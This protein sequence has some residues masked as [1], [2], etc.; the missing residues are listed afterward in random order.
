MIYK[1]IGFLLLMLLYTNSYS[2]NTGFE[3]VLEI[4][5]NELLGTFITDMTMGSDGTIAVALNDLSRVHLYDLKGELISEYG[6]SGR[7][8]GDFSN[9]MSVHVSDSIIYAMDAGP[10]GKVNAF[11]KNDPG[12]FQ[13]FGIPR[14]RNSF[15]LRMWAL[16]GGKFVVE[17]R[18]SYSNMNLEKTIMST[19]SVISVKDERLLN[20]VFQHESAEKFINSS[21]GGFSISDMPYGRENFVMPIEG[22]IYHNWSGKKNVTRLNINNADT[23]DVIEPQFSA[24]RLSLNDQ[25]YRRYFLRELGIS[26]GDNFNEVI[27]EL[28]NDPSTRARIRGLQAKL[29]NRDELHHTFPV[30]EWVVGDS[31]SLCFGVPDAD[32]SLTRVECTDLNG[33]VSRSG[34]IGSSVNILGLQDQ[35]LYGTRALETG[36]TSVVV[37]EMR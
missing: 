20:E 18:P 3:P 29:E 2:Q 11:D 30:Y 10:G 31:G 9:L 17:Y 13:A 36:L 26:D 14:M 22:E 23:I 32:R 8:P 33:E 5:P 28:A 24:E 1:A 27:E 21:D 12:R 35:Y 25:D 19:Y 34:S 7:G 4:E 37:Y 6:R 15:P 16:D